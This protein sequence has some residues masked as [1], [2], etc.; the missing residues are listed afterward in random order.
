MLVFFLGAGIVSM[1]V[2]VMGKVRGLISISQL[3][4]PSSVVSE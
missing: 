4:R 3:L 2:I 1:L